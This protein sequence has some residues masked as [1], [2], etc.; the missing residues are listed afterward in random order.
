MFHDFAK[1][2]HLAS[3]FQMFISCDV[4]DQRKYFDE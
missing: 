2:A 3:D 1:L 4:R